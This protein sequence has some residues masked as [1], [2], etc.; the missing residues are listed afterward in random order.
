VST[1][2]LYAGAELL[3]KDPNA[4]IQGLFQVLRLIFGSQIPPWVVR[5]VGYVLAFGLLLLALWGVLYVLDRI[6]S[7]WAERFR[8]L[9]YDAEKKKE[10]LFR[11]RFADHI[12]SEIRR[13]NNLEQWSDYRYAELEAEVEAEGYRRSVLPFRAYQ[14]PSLR[15]EK[16]LSRAL[17][18]SRERLIL[19]EGEPGSGKSVALR[20][21]AQELAHKAISAKRTDE[22]VPIYVNLKGLTRDSSEAISPD[23]IRR[24]TLSSLNRMSNRDVEEFLDRE[25][26]KGSH[27]GTWLF[28]FDSFDEIPEVLSSVEADST[29]GAYAEALDGFLGGFNRCRGII[30]SR[31]F[32]GPRRLD[33]PRFR[34]LALTQRRRADLVGR[35]GLATD[36]ENQLLAQVER[37]TESIRVM[38]S[39]PM[40]LGLLIDYVKAEKRPPET[41][42][43]VFER[44]IQRRLD[45]DSDKLQRKYALAPSQLRAVAEAAAFC[46]A[47]DPA[48]GLTPSR[49]DLQ[50][51]INRLGFALGD[52]LPRALNALEYIRIARS[53]AYTSPGEENPP[54]TFSHRRFQEYFATCVVLGEPQRISAQQLLLDGRWRETAVV[55]FQTQSSTSIQ[56]LLDAARDILV[57]FGKLAKPSSRVPSIAPPAGDADLASLATFP[58]PE[59]SIHLLGTLQEGFAGKYDQ[60]PVEIRTLCGEVVER[61]STLGGIL[62]RKWALEVAAAA[63]STVL[64]SLLRAAFP[65][66]SQWLRDTAYRQTARLVSLPVDI[67][68]WIRCSLIDL[69]LSG[70]LHRQRI[71]TEVHLSRLDCGKGLLSVARLM[72]CVPAIDLLLFCTFFTLCLGRL[73]VPPLEVSML[74]ILAVALAAVSVALLVE[75]REAFTTLVV[76]YAARALREV[77]FN[78][79]VRLGITITWVIC[80][81]VKPL[82][83]S[84]FGL[85]REIRSDPWL[86]LFGLY[87]AIWAPLA[88]GAAYVQECVHPLFWPF[89][90]LLPVV[91]L[92]R[93][94]RER[95]RALYRTF[96]GSRHPARRVAI[97][98]VGTLCLVFFGPLVR[99]IVFVNDFVSAHALLKICG[100]VILAAIYSLPMCMLVAQICYWVPRLVSDCRRWRRLHDDDRSPR[101]DLASIVKELCGFYFGSFRWRSIRFCRETGSLPL[102]LE[103]EQCFIAVTHEDIKGARSMSRPWAWKALAKAGMAIPEAFVQDPRRFDCWDPKSKDEVYRLMEAIRSNPSYDDWLRR[104]GNPPSSA[105]A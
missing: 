60:L 52:N 11:N 81:L 18:R 20:H 85:I 73:H 55:L 77:M 19:L 84:A 22:I 38:A 68:R 23:L 25:F 58:W 67:A 5:I 24:F 50:L 80:V 92:C 3:P 40:F 27:D 21:L 54:F 34:V 32:R 98:S 1:I 13:L 78:V 33:W 49:K 101:T 6:R 37:G 99:A 35:A 71:E 79:A 91:Y 100:I 2:G 46:M 26:D 30:A 57:R 45:R 63:P 17:G 82:P 56:F 28:L 9:F 86:F 69:A 15:R 39:N 43:I 42:H 36:A 72:V 90:P 95:V 31:Q 47:A 83:R 41:A 94:S 59:R 96:L 76:R 8:P 103:S 53:E 62:D 61:A 51:S 12:E 14:R 88:C 104:F 97:F 74:G 29:I 75:L 44:Y 10:A 70:R 4:W 48:L 64:L 93:N 16:S 87:T 66:T 7:L 102:T 89:I 65:S 105:K